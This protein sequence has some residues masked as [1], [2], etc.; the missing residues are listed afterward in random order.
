MVPV[1]FPLNQSIDSSAGS[2]CSSGK[3]SA[4]FFAGTF[5]RP[6]RPTDG[7]LSKP[8]ADFFHVAFSA[9]VRYSAKP[10]TG[11]QDLQTN[12]NLHLD[13]IRLKQFGELQ[14]EFV[15]VM[16]GTK[17]RWEV[18]TSNDDHCKTFQCSS[19]NA[20]STSFSFPFQC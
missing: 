8:A 2:E 1:D 7:W 14:A 4:W 11:P 19:A 5:A 17:P 10:D 12:L 18:A 16:K 13:L 6:P 15:K 20:P 9:L 3:S